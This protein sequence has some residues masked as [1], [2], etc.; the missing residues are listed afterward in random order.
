M[1]DLSFNSAP[2]CDVL[3]RSDPPAVACWTLANRDDPP[4]DQVVDPIRR[5]PCGG[6]QHSLNKRVLLSDG[7]HPCRDTVLQY[8]SLRGTCPGKVGRQLIEVSVS[9]IA[10]Q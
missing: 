8:L 2:L 6:R 3:V 5:P 4:I 1:L 10:G 7:V 9:R